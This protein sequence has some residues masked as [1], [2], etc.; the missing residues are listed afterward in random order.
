MGKSERTVFNSATQ[1][2]RSFESILECI[3]A[4]GSFQ[5]VDKDM[6]LKFQP[7]LFEYLRDFKIW[8]VPDELKLTKRIKRSLTTLYSVNGHLSHKT[9]S[10]LRIE[11]KTQI[12]RLR[13]KLE[14]I[15]G[16]DCLDEF[17]RLRSAQVAVQH[18][19]ID[20]SYETNQTHF[21][22]EELIHELLI[23]PAFQL[24]CCDGVYIDGE[25]DSNH[26]L[27]KL[28]YQVGVATNKS[29]SPA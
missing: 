1:M 14:Q 8:K 26:Y 29:V 24:R 2:L 19:E 11:F 17:D 25:A 4:N 23:D 9:D 6:S 12:S 13:G 22:N 5:G 21:T 3:K 20:D 27:R 10:N 15:A 16:K 18:V 28:F 7:L